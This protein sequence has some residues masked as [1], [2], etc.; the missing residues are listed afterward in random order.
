MDIMLYVMVRVRVGD[1]YVSSDISVSLQSLEWQLC[2]ADDITAKTRTYIFYIV[3]IV[4]ADDLVMQGA[5]AS[6]TMILT[7]LVKLE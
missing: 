1:F 5:R 3:S 7:Y 2:L 4:G 6:A